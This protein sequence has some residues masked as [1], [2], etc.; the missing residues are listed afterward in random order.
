MQMH[1]NC[2][3]TGY[4]LDGMKV[5]LLGQLQPRSINMSMCFGFQFLLSKYS[6]ELVL[7][8]MDAS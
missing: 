6:L 4:S 3:L 1:V 7:I 2:W 8:R 5:R